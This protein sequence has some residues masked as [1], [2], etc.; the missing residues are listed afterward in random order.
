MV[1]GIINGSGGD[2]SS[3]SGSGNGDTGRIVN[4]SDNGVVAVVEVT[5]AR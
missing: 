1:I 4:S 2:S 3:G 5:V